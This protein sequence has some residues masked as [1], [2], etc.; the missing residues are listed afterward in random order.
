MYLRSTTQTRH[1]PLNL[2]SQIH[3]K[4]NLPAKAHDCRVPVRQDYRSRTRLGHADGRAQVSGP[5]AM[6][7]AVAEKTQSHLI[8]ILLGIFFSNLCGDSGIYG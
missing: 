1:R 3:Q 4:Y 7:G 2:T 8:E 5:W 6:K